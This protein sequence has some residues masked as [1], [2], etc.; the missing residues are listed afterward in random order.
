LLANPERLESFLEKEIC[1]LPID[2][3][4]LGICGAESV[5]R[6]IDQIKMEWRIAL[7]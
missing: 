7:S 6:V 2:L 4:I 5:L 3:E 1:R